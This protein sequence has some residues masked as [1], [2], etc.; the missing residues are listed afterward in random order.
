MMQLLPARSATATTTDPA[1]W[2]FLQI[3]DAAE[4]DLG[5]CGFAGPLR[6]EKNRRH[7]VHLASSGYRFIGFCSHGE[8]PNENWVYPCEAWC[9]GY[10]DPGRRLP[11]HVPWVNLSES[12]FASVDNIQQGARSAGAAG[13]A[14]DYVVV[15]L[16]GWPSPVKHPELARACCWELS[17]LGLRGLFVGDASP[18]ILPP[19]TVYESFLPWHELMASIA[20]ARFVVFTSEIDASPRLITESLCLNKPIVVYERLLQG[21]KYVTPESGEFFSGA[22]D[23]CAAALKVLSQARRP[24]DWFHR[25][26]GLR[27][28][29]AHLFSVLKRLQPDLRADGNI[30]RIIR[31]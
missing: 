24:L 25:Q 21:F 3:V 27:H 17:R 30:A 19:G 13:H 26:H 23:V 14:T 9:H 8:F 7:Y 2:P 10:R 5:W 12:D 28:A 4:R 16:P 22:Q 11:P 6:E 15:A 29:S 18:S 1:K 31:R 20:R